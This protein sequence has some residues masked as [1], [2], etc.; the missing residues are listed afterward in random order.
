VISKIELQ[1]GARLARIVA[2]RGYLGRNAPPDHKMKGYISGQKRGI[3]EAIKR[4][5]RRRSAVEPVIGQVTG[6]HRM[7]RNF[8]K[9]A[10][11]D[12]SNAV[13]AAAGCNFRRLPC[14]FA[15]LCRVFVIATL[16][17]VGRR[18][19]AAR[20]PLSLTQSASP[21]RTRFADDFMKKARVNKW[22]CATVYPKSECVI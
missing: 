7:G 18:P 11:G 22:R 3:T 1:K 6:E 19:G 13:L 9:G 2:D 5:L 16:A 21:S 8:L 20:R 12:A 17:G 4:D 15:I 14:W 10:H